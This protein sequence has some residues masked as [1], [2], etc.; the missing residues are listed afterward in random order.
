[1]TYQEDIDLPDLLK[2]QFNHHVT[3]R[4]RRPGVV[5]LIAPLYAA[6]SRRNRMRALL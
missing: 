4:E 5:Q 6:S 1:M 2:E 3:F